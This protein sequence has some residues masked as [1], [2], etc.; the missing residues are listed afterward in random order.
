MTAADRTLAALVRGLIVAAPFVRPVWQK[1]DPRHSDLLRAHQSIR[2]REPEDPWGQPW[3]RTLWATGTPSD[4]YKAGS[5][6]P[7]TRVGTPDD[8]EIC[9]EVLNA[10]GEYRIV[11]VGPRS[12]TAWPAWSSAA[13]SIPTNQTIQHL[14]AAR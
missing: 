13:Q 12:P 7:D 5:A 2:A 4:L 11:G 6:G 1:L 10:D 14:L 3:I 9:I 8:I